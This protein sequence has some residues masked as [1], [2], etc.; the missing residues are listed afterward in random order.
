MIDFNFPSKNELLISLQVYSILSIVNNDMITLPLIVL[1]SN[2]IKLVGFLVRKIFEV[3]LVLIFLVFFISTT[4]SKLDP[5]NYT[6]I[7]HEDDLQLRLL[8]SPT[9]LMQV[10]KKLCLR[11]KEG[12][13]IRSK[14]SVVVNYLILRI[15]NNNKKESILIVCVVQSFFMILL[16][17]FLLVA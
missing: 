11:S 9:K 3:K 6:T 14:T 12:I 13:I 4:L 17:L 16:K 8:A 7:R 2:S 1:I 10:L 15:L 5:K